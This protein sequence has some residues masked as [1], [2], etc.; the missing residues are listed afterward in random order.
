MRCYFYSTHFFF[1]GCIKLS[2]SILYT[3]LV[4]KIPF[5]LFWGLP[6]S[7]SCNKTDIHFKKK[8]VGKPC[9]KRRVNISQV[10]CSRDVSFAHSH[11]FSSSLYKI[12][13]RVAYIQEDARQQ[14]MEKQCKLQTTT[15]V[16]RS[17]CLAAAMYCLIYNNNNY[18]YYTQHELTMGKQNKQKKKQLNLV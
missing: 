17:C 2:S 16:Q 14:K 13:Y 7:P 15:T 8:D 18:Y 6:T 4:A 10:N 5:N 3:A 9:G 12:Q 1:F 11:H